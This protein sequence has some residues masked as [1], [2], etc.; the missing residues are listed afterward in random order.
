MLIKQISRSYIEIICQKEDKDYSNAVKFSKEIVIKKS[1]VLSVYNN[2]STYFL[3]TY[4]YMCYCCYCCCSCCSCCFISFVYLS[5]VVL[6]S[7]VMLDS[8]SKTLILQESLS[9]NIL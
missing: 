5:M 2:F 1:S 8:S 4:Y 9:R 7:V 6:K 3:Q